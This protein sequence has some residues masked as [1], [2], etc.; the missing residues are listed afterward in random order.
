M[1][2]RPHSV[3][4]HG[5]VSPGCTGS[6][7]QSSYVHE[8]PSGFHLGSRNTSGMFSGLLLSSLGSSE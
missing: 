4:A 6:W 2:D 3:L 1:V 7:S 5:R 8:G